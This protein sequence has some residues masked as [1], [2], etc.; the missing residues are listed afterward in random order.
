M[1]PFIYRWSTNHATPSKAWGQGWDAVDGCKAR[2]FSWLRGSHTR[3]SHFTR[4]PH[5]TSP[6]QTRVSSYMKLAETGVRDG[7]WLGLINVI[8]RSLIRCLVSSFEACGRCAVC[9][10]SISCREVR[11]GS[12]GSQEKTLC[13]ILETP[14]FGDRFKAFRVS[15]SRV[16]KLGNLLLFF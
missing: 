2:T 1:D 8:I 6:Q 15:R 3:H 14:V 5:T 16:I 9:I 12:G 13:F 4:R 10:S 11:T 7:R